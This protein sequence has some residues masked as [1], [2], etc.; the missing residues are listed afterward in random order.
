MH[1]ICAEVVKDILKYIWLSHLC[2]Q[3]LDFFVKL[4]KK[5]AMFWKYIAASK[6]EL[7]SGDDD[8]AALLPSRRME[9]S[10]F[11]Q[12]LEAGRLVPGAQADRQQP[13]PVPL[14]PEVN[15]DVTRS[16]RAPFSAKN[17]PSSSS[18]LT[19]LDGGVAKGYVEIPQ[20]I[21]L[22]LYSSA[23]K[24]LP[25]GGVNYA[26]RPWPVSSRSVWTVPSESGPCA[27]FRCPTAGTSV[28]TL[29]PLVWSLGAW[30]ALPRLFRWLLRTIRLG[31]MIQFARRPPKFSVLKSRSCWR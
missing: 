1:F 20:S 13:P 6:G 2:V 4:W 31:Y 21:T 10:S 9:A 17:G 27:P 15:E 3:F 25:L 18:V 14:F 19:T 8:S 26:F 12:M 29:V 23:P 22:L 16:W 24:A 28:A 5:E 7:G 30:L 11:S